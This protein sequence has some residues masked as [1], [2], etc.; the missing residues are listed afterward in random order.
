MA[1]Q[2]RIPAAIFDDDIIEGTETITL[3][4]DSIMHGS[5]DIDPLHASASIDIEDNDFVAL[6]VSSSSRVPERGTGSF[7]FTLD[8]AIASPL[9]ISISVG[10]T[11]TEGTDYAPVARKITIP[12][13]QTKIQADVTINHDVVNEG[14]ETIVVQG[15]ICFQRCGR[16][17]P[18]RRFGNPDHYRMTTCCLRYPCSRLR[19][20]KTRGK[21]HSW[22]SCQGRAAGR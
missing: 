2:A 12:A 4:I 20:S 11:A 17:I 16:V 18:A 9:E 22:P 10:G 7:I 3:T 13:G 1:N 5:A 21:Y 14:D 6:S 19:L 15:R 8:K